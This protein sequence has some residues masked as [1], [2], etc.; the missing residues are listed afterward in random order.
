MSLAWYVAKRLYSHGGGSR[1]VSR[2]AILI[3]TWGVALG[4]AV[5]VISVAVVLGFKRGVRDKVTG[6]GSH[7]Q[8]VN[9]E[10]LYSPEISPIQM[11]D[12]LLEALR[13]V[14][15]VRSVRPFCQKTGMLKTDEAFQGV[16]F[17]GVEENYDLSF[18][19]SQLTEGEMDEPFHKDKNTNRLVVSSYMADQLSL[20][21]G[22]KVYAYFFSGELRAR[23]FTVSAVYA[24]NMSE[25]DRNL[26]FCDYAAVHQLLGYE[27]DQ[28]SGA[29][30]EIND[31]DSLEQVAARVNALTKHRM[32]DYGGYYT[33]PTIKDL[34]PNIFSWLD[35]LDLNVIVILVLMTAVACFTTVCG[36]LILVL[37][38]T[39]F[40]GVMKALGARNRQL[41]TVFIYYALFIIVKG[42]ILGD[43]LGIAICLLQKHFALVRLD[44]STYYVSSVPI[45]MN[46][47]LTVALSLGVLVVSVLVLV[48]PSYLVSN[49]QPAKSIRFE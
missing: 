22:S 13:D 27:L 12:S 21:V 1:K 32:D 39:Q 3:A 18:L 40:I 33:S 2:P 11:K 48:V 49:I 19:R 46:W 9:Y 42:V 30:V 43:V 4:L 14:Q 24:T 41:R 36:L 8:V 20:H 7:I 34:F 44:P 47:P 38:R 6:M 10:S 26:V 5:M 16:A 29:E 15:G 45:L 17:R 37:E 28:A 25:H 23:R 35:L 31:F